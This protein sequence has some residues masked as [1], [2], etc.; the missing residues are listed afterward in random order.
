MFTHRNTCA[1][2]IQRGQVL[3]LALVFASIMLTSLGSLVGYVTLGARTQRQSVATAQAL[4]LAEG[5]IDKAVYEL[6][7]NGGYAGETNTSLPGGTFVT[8]VVTAGA[9]KNITVTGYVPDQASP[10][11]V[12]TVQATA[13]INTSIVSF[14]F[15]VQIG[16]GGLSMGN[17]STVNGSIYS[18][19]NISGSGTIT[20]DATVAL[21]VDD[22]PD[23]QSQTQN[24]GFN[25]GDTSTRSDVAMGFRPSVSALLSRTTLNIKKVG[26]PSDIAIKI[27]TDNSGKPS[28]T[29]LATGAI[30]AALVGSSYSHID[31]T[32]SSTA[33]LTASTQYWI[34]ADASVNASNYYVWGDDTGNGYANGT[35][36]Y[37]TNWNASTPTWSNVNADMSFRTYMEGAITSLS[38]VTVQGD[39]WAHSLSGCIIGGDA[40]YQTISGCSVG[41][42]SNPGSVDA[43]AAP[44]PISAAQIADWEVIA[45]AGGTI[46]GPHTVSG[47]E[48]LGPIK[49]TGGLTTTNGAKLVLS[50]PV[51][52]TGD[53]DFS[54]NAELSVDAGTGSSGAILI[55][56]DPTNTANKGEVTISNNVTISGNG[57][58]DSHPMIITTNSGS[59][60]IN[61]ENNGASV[62][63]YAPYGTV[64]VSNNASGN[65]ITANKLT[66]SN[67]SSVNYVSGLQNAS[68][69]N[70]PGGSWAI[71]PGTYVITQ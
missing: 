43:S 61:L 3:L 28:K 5:G 42:T 18:N 48:T 71:V 46:T 12:R 23:Q 63:L 58:P 36:K 25:L 70:G 37:S 51:W 31:V 14:V 57:N 66:L 6:N 55:A 45:A 39:A 33:A 17:G 26:S 21:G 50:G 32:Y 52:V 41:G 47:T 29:V 10:V 34:I 56:D 59:N 9:L 24:S 68:F 1:R 62:I 40:S 20:G 64:D 8:S 11:A 19:G 44:L 35:G 7:Q 54:N 38:G 27:V 4:A 22:N 2:S 15:G 53:V 69:S 13:S 16:N 30:S 65:Q 49:I 67:N 60:A